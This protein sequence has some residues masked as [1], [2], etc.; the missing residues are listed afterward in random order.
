MDL[1]PGQGTKIPRKVMLDGQ[2][3]EKKK[4]NPSFLKTDS[5]F[6]FLIWILTDRWF[7]IALGRE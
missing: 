7:F 4:M 3:G 1:V 5:A 6:C 2:K